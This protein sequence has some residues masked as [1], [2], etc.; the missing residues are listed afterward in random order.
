MCQNRF[1]RYGPPPSGRKP[2]HA[3]NVGYD[4]GK[5]WSYGHSFDAAA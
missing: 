4:G 5:V 3:D 1:S 2:F